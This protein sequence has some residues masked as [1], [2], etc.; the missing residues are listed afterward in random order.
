MKQKL[1][2]VE[3]SGGEFLLYKRIYH[4]TG[5]LPWLSPGK[6]LLPNSLQT[7]LVDSPVFKASVLLGCVKVSLNGGEIR[8]FKGET[9]CM[10]SLWP[11]LFFEQK[12]KVWA[13]GSS[14]N[15]APLAL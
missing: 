6:S 11:L 2:S 13:C 10:W 5:G 9:L 12:D 8:C 1:T 4:F 15:T 3:K 14:Q 7:Y